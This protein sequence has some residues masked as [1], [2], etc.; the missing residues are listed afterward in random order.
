MI[1]SLEGTTAKLSIERNTSDNEG[2]AFSHFNPAQNQKRKNEM[3]QQNTVKRGSF[4]GDKAQ[5]SNKDMT[6][7]IE[8]VSYWDPII[9]SRIEISTTNTG[10]KPL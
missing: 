1:E 4:N 10:M 6:P 5:S 3:K 8:L 7:K 9:E 2:P